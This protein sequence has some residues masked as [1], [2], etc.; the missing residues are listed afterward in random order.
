MLLELIVPFNLAIFEDCIHVCLTG[1]EKGRQEI[2]QILVRRQVTVVRNHLC[3]MRI[4]R[5]LF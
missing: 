5:K 1:M 3:E 4:S 2:K